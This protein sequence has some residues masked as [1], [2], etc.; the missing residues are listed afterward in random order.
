[1]GSLIT[2]VVPMYCEEN[3]VYEFYDRLKKVIDI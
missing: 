1:M 3:L 2:I